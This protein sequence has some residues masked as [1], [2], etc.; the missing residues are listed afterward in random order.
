VTLVKAPA[1]VAP[2]TAAGPPDAARARPTWLLP[3]T[4]VVLL[5]ILIVSVVVAVAIGPVTIGFG[6][7]W[8]IIGHAVL[9][10]LVGTHGTGNESIIALD[11]RAPRVLL[12]AVVGAGLGV[13]G[14]VLQA[15]LRNPLADP[16]IVGLSSGAALGAVLVLLGGTIGIGATG[17]GLAGQLGTSGGA[18]AGALLAFALV[19][20]FG[21]RRGQISPLR[22]L[23]GGVA[24]AALLSAATNWVVLTSDNQQVRSALYW[25]LGSLTGSTW[26]DLTLPAL[27][28]VLLTGWFTLQGRTL[29]ALS[30]GD[31]HAATLG[32][33]VN[34]ART[35]LTAV[36]AL[37]VAVTVAVSGSILFFAL[38]VPHLVRLVLGA[39][40][41]ILLPISA[42]LGAVLLIW[43]D[44]AARML[45]APAEM[46][47]GVVT[48]LLG[49]PAFLLLMLRQANR[50]A[51]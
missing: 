5:A 40:Y 49:A 36:A 25:T 39:D 1:A 24:V 42:L 38:V 31:E 41:R 11:L 27:A 26:S 47:I 33:S 45:I 34:R 18:F 28:V 20:V 2:E 17:V 43:F 14:A 51:G 37:L 16:Y 48:S 7:I 29:N 22:M 13:A 35:S 44:V 10:G 4:S 9:P 3:A 50:S 15:V 32:I 23:L 12:G 30:L 19:W 6:R 8:G 21:R 46:P